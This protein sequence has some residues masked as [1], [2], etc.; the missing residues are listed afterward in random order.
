MTATLEDRLRHHYNER[1]R[2][3]PEHG[4]GLD[5]GAVL[6]LQ[7]V[8]L[9]PRSNRA[10]RVALVIGSVAA[11]TV[12]GFALINRPT[13][14][15]PGVGSVGSN[16]P[17]TSA[18][19]TVEALV[20]AQTLPDRA[21]VSVTPETVAASSPTHWYRLQPD[22]DVAWFQEPNGQSPS[23]L[24]WRTPA[25]SECVPDEFPGVPLIVP[26]AGGQTLVVAGRMMGTGTLDVQLTSGA[27][28]SAP[29]EMDETIGWGVARYQLPDGEKIIAV[30]DASVRASEAADVPGQTLPPAVGLND[31]PV[32]IPA[33]SELS[34]WRWF[35]DLDISERQ[36]AA[37]GTEL[38]W[39]TPAGTGCIDDSFISP[40]VGIIPTDGGAI[41][42]A[43]PA[44]MAI[45]PTPTDPLAPKFE[46]G[47]P[48]R[49][50]TVALSDGSAVTADIN[51]GDQFG[52]GYGRI[53]LAA[54]VTIVSATSS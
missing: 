30:G 5:S 28:L 20:P 10:A 29:F 45:T 44:L 18:E 11:A 15:Q 12:L 31:T 53:T 27:V 41:L 21:D 42:L 37:G 49:T 48:P 47:P 1:T 34:Y 23:M 43:R 7:P 9:E 40:E 24:C 2:D 16:S 46:Q 17:K 6:R 36:T 54:G 38:C 25:V 14:E 4:P 3:T 51:Y 32:T 52:V 35:P 8:H 22:L 50:I 33:G 26:T 13:T 39:R 19:E